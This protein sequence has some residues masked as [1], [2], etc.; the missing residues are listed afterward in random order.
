[1]EF[2]VAAALSICSNLNLSAQAITG[3]QITWSI[4]TMT[5]TMVANPQSIARVFPLLAA[6]CR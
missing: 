6:V 3:R 2:C 5:D 1:M 4:T